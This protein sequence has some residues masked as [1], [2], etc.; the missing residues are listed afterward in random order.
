LIS[1]SGQALSRR[2]LRASVRS[3]A[4]RFPV[5]VLRSAA[6]EL[7]SSGSPPYRT[8][9]PSVSPRTAGKGVSS[10]V[11]RYRATMRASIE[12]SQHPDEKPQRLHLRR[13]CSIPLGAN[14]ISRSSPREANPVPRYDQRLSRSTL[15]DAKRQGPNSIRGAAVRDPTGCVAI[16]RGASNERRSPL[17][18]AIQDVKQ[19]DRTPSSR[20]LV[21]VT[22][23]IFPGNRENNREYHCTVSRRI[24]KPN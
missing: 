20:S 19:Q 9:A 18:V 16:P 3:S 13:L 23:A 22:H 24:K 21:F 10:G 15:A 5:C 14:C 7:R 4:I 17:I 1:R 2:R 6:H 8:I 12:S 11:E